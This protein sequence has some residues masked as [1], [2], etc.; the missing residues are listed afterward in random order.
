[1]DGDDAPAG[2]Q[3]PGIVESSI[4][5]EHTEW[6][7]NSRGRPVA[8]R[9]GVDVFSPSGAFLGRLEGDELWNGVYRGELVRGD[10]LVRS[11]AARGD[12]RELPPP[13]QPVQVPTSPAGGRGAIGL[14]AG[15]H[16]VR[17]D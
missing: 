11:Y 9:S 2:A 14:P 17:F 3:L 10:R 12:D 8:F 1:M 7:F 6:L 13:R 15:F 5:E 4:E 16:D